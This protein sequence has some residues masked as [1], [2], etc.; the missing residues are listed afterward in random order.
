MIW[1]AELC[2]LPL[3]F[4]FVS[5]EFYHLVL[6]SVFLVETCLPKSQKNDDDDATV[7]NE[8]ACHAF[9]LNQRIAE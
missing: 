2:L 7:R 6:T 8:S 4:P 3:S 1:L 9:H 5:L